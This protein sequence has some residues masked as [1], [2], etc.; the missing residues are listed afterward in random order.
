MNKT[1]NSMQNTLANQFRLKFYFKLI[2]IYFQ[3]KHKFDCNSHRIKA[4]LIETWDDTN[5]QGV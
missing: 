4:K 5:E 3:I 2:S 1:L